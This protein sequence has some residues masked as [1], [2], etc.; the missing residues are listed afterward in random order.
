VFYVLFFNL[1]QHFVNILST[2]LH[3]YLGLLFNVFCFTHIVDHTGW[4]FQSWKFWRFA[5]SQ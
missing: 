4:L 3:C 5:C 1:Q 2:C